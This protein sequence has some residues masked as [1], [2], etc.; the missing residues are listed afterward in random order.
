MDTY[1][2]IS[3]VFYY[4][5]VKKQLINMSTGEIHSEKQ[6]IEKILSILREDKEYNRSVEKQLRKDFDLPT[7]IEKYQH[8]WKD[9]SW[10]IKIYRTEMREYKKSI[11]LSPSA[12]L[13]LVY[14]QDYIEYKTNRLVNKKGKTF[15]NKE[16]SNLLGISE[17]PML[18]ALNELEE[19]YF[20]K[21]VGS[22]RSREIYFNP[23][24]ACSGNEISKETLDMFQN[25]IAL[26]PY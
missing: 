4:D 14:L 26:T 2:R 8:N 17:N 7:E 21:R 20:I 10:F 24:L 16:L 13:L 22:R 12:G 23:Y 3:N 9:G 5:P 15:T 1:I 25:Y 6:D 18:N 19:K 11:K